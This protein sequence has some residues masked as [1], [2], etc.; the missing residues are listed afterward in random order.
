MTNISKP[1]TNFVLSSITEK[2]D[3][4]SEQFTQSN[5][6][7]LQFSAHMFNV[8][9]TFPSSTGKPHFIISCK[10]LDSNYL[11]VTF[12]LLRLFLVL[13]MSCCEVI[14]VFDAVTFVVFSLKRAL[15]GGA[16]L[17]VERVGAG[18]P[19]CTVTLLPG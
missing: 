12:L 19:F 8:F 6:H 15:L 17:L 10:N 2:V 9:S 1:S 13:F 11:V 5:L 7:K 16:V 4:Y 14:Y 3:Y 18:A